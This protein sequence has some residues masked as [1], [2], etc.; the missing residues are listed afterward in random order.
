MKLGTKIFCTTLLLISL[1][2]YY[3]I[4]QFIGTLRIRYLEGIEDSLVDQAYILAALA[5][6]QM[7]GEGPFSPS[8]HTWFDQVYQQHFQATIYALTKTHVDMRVYITD[9]AGRLLFDSQRLLPP[10][11]DFSQWRNISLTLAGQYG[12]RTSR[13]TTTD[14]ASSVLHISAPIIGDKAKLLG[15]L[16]VA[17]PTGNV[18]YFLQQARPRIIVTSLLTLTVAGFFSYLFAVLLTR[19]IQRLTAYALRVKDGEPARRPELGGGEIAAMGEAFFQMQEALEGKNYIEQYIQNLTHEMK[20]PLSSIRGAAELLNEPMPPEMQ[21]RF[22]KN[23]LEDT[24]RLQEMIDRMLELAALE[25]RQAPPRLDAVAVSALLGQL[26]ESV[27]PL[28]ERKE[29]SLILP[30]DSGATVTADSFLLQRALN[31]LLVNSIDFSPAG[32]TIT[33]TVEH[34]THNLTIGIADQGPGIPVF[35]KERIFE[36]FYSLERPQTGKKSTGL[37]LNFVRQVATLHR[38][39]IELENRPEGGVLAVLS[40]P[41]DTSSYPSIRK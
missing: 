5:Q 33:I 3:P 2:L 14:Q 26:A 1:S 30:P 10:G 28:L 19:P 29:I 8:W 27:Q 20:S 40:L 22:V 16:T 12:A 36:K 21:Q 11:S 18:I 35:A 41:G 37:G 34:S 13:L 31:N 38:G 23:I 15:V 17:K 9:T 32:G 25:N 4:N 6:E 24:R 7:T 39:T